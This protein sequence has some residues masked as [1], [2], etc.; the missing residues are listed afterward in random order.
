MNK[1]SSTLL[2]SA[3]LSARLLF[4]LIKTLDVFFE[5]KSNIQNCPSELALDQSDVTSVMFF[6]LLN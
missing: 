1:S 3:H 2:V 5:W 6:V 4:T